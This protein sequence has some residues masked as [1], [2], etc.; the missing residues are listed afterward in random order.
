VPQGEARTRIG[1]PME[2]PVAIFFGSIHPSKGV[3]DVITAWPEVLSLVPDARLVIVGKPVRVDPRQIRTPADRRPRGI[4][5]RPNP[6]R[7]CEPRRGQ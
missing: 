7:T 1:L 4:G 6:V 3:S 5:Q 2:A